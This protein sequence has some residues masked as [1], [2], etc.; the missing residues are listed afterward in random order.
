MWEAK[1]EKGSLSAIRSVGTLVCKTDASVKKRCVVKAPA[2][3]NPQITGGLRDILTKLSVF[4]GIGTFSHPTQT[5][6]LLELEHSS[7]TGEAPG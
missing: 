3:T 7:P 4:A 5:A 6:W 2:S 1:R